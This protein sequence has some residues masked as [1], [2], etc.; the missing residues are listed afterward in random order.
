ME[1]V[2]DHVTFVTTSCQPL[3]ICYSSMLSLWWLRPSPYRI[4]K[5]FRF[6]VTCFWQRQCPLTELL[7]SLGRIFTS[8]CSNYILLYLCSQLFTE[9]LLSV[10]WIR[11]S[12]V[13]VW[14]L[15]P[16]S[17]TY[18]FEKKALLYPRWS[19]RPSLHSNVGKREFSESASA[20]QWFEAAYRNQ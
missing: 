13:T 17:T 15:D 18:R 9:L 6:P 14:K 5:M 3:C 12:C 2:I 1:D 7:L 19:V 11:F 10:A 16:H 8:P 20:V 4:H